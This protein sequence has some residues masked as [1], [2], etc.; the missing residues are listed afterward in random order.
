MRIA[1]TEYAIRIF[2][3]E[4]STVSVEVYKPELSF[5]TVIPAKVN[6]GSIGA[7][8]PERAKLYAEAL[9]KASELAEELN[10]ELA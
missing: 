1:E 9:L 3:F 10:K 8:E 7:G 5:G 4:G 2:P 6:W